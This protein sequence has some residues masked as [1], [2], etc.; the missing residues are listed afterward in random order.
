MECHQPRH[1]HRY[2][3]GSVR[4]RNGNRWFYFPKPT[5]RTSRLQPDP[6]VGLIFNLWLQK[7]F[8]S[9]FHPCLLPCSL[10][11]I[12]LNCQ[13]VLNGLELIFHLDARYMPIGTKAQKN[14]WHPMSA[15]CFMYWELIFHC[16]QGFF[17]L[18]GVGFLFGV[19]GCLDLGLVGSWFLLLMLLFGGEWKFFFL[20]PSL[21]DYN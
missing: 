2:Q 9:F 6:P 17:C 5:Y 20:F 16:S 4:Y 3:E 15:V 13:A 19:F 11:P 12:G 18:S 10:Y 21:V 14:R 7:M 8:N 1:C